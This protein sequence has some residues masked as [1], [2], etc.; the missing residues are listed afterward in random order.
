MELGKTDAQDFNHGNEAA[1]QGQRSQESHINFSGGGGVA[2]KNKDP[3]PK[4]NVTLKRLKCNLDDLTGAVINNQRCGRSA[5]S[6]EPGIKLALLI[7][8]LMNTFIRADRSLRAAAG[9]GHK[10]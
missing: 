6:S 3:A 10:Y 5:V 7:T 2:K 8:P 4:R 1:L 9:D